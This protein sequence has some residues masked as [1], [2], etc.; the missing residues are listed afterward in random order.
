MSPR[1]YDMTR[2]RSIAAETRRRIVDATLKL[3]GER[4]IFGTT[5][6]DIAGEAD[7]AI[8]TVYRYFPSLDELVPA[9]GELLMERTGPPRPEDIEAI[10]GDA[11]GPMSRLKRVADALFGFYARAGRYL[12]A[13]LRERELPAVREWEEYLRGLVEGFVR[14]ALAGVPT[15]PDVVGRLC[16]LFDVP[17]LAAMRVRGIEPDEASAIIAGL[18]GSWLGL[19]PDP[20]VVEKKGDGKR[21]RRK[22]TTIR[23]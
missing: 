22:T 17:T 12:E 1:R 11:V 8:G 3:H 13:D 21:E 16:F 10:L 23:S 6:A 5:W 18:A 7:V 2:K 19:E 20:G 15:N 4:G 9:C 14:G